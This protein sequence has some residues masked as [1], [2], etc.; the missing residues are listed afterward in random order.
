[1]RDLSRLVRVR[2]AGGCRRRQYQQS[3]DQ[4]DRHFLGMLSTSEQ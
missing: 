2:A 1:M 3:N 4:F